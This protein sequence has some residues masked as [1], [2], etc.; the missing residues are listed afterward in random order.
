MDRQEG[1]AEVRGAMRDIMAGKTMIVRFIALGP[2]NSAFTILGIQ[3]TDSWYVS[4]SEDLLYRAGFDQFV[5]AAQKATSYASST[6][7]VN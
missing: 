3:C 2:T 1:L 4:H 5:K 7:P 6:Q